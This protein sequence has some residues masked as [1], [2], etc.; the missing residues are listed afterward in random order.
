[1]KRDLWSQQPDLYTPTRC[2]QPAYFAPSYIPMGGDVHRFDGWGGT[3]QQAA[4]HRSHRSASAGSVRTR[5]FEGAGFPNGHLYAEGRQRRDPA[6]YGRSN[7][8]GRRSSIE[9]GI[10]SWADGER[11]QKPSRSMRQLARSQQQDPVQIPA[12]IAAY[13]GGLLRQDGTQNMSLSRHSLVHGHGNDVTSE[14]LPNI[15]AHP[16]HSN[17]QLYGS[18]PVRSETFQRPPQ[19]SESGATTRHLHGQNLEDGDQ[20][21]RLSQTE[22]S[23][24]VLVQ[25][26]VIE[27]QVVACEN[28]HADA[29]RGTG[30]EDLH[31]P[32]KLR[33]GSG[34]HPSQISDQPGDP[35][36]YGDRKVLENFEERE[37]KEI[38]VRAPLQS[39][40]E[41]QDW[42]NQVT[43]STFAVQE[44]QALRYMIAIS[45]L[46]VFARDFMPWG[47]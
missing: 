5:V 42:K 17:H 19:T 37:D 23:D 20:S 21:R 31:S 35:R 38:A 1:M 14:L 45:N 12:E 24:P 26:T 10:H 18:P 30:T 8:P 7:V 36:D 6:R 43:S 3:H 47:V 16:P 44:V 40:I 41:S 46:F 39:T 2:P 32:E 4:A 34:Q 22:R 13:V 27:Q 9:I 29:N 28:V 11:R 25:E 15:Q 33:E